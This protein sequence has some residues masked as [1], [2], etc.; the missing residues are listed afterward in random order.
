MEMSSTQKILIWYEQ[1]TW[2]RALL[3]V[4]P[5]GASLDILLTGKAAQINQ[6]RLN[7]L[8]E[9]IES[10]VR[11]LEKPLSPKFLQSENFFELFRT[12]A[13]IVCRSASHEKRSIVADCLAGA[14][15]VETVTDL[16]LQVMED[17]RSM[18][19]MHIQVLTAI[20]KIKGQEV[21]KTQ[22]PESLQNMPEEVY[23]KAIADL[24]RYGFIR[25][26]TAG[27]G[28]FGGGSGRWQTTSYVP[29]FHS[30][31]NTACAL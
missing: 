8:I 10:R 26:N 16:R 19:M 31:I 29:I 30:Q 20:P 1:A 22:K 15:Q 13:E 7:E 24:E 27:I 21:S 11:M 17:L 14:I 23:E 3:Q 18:H 2:L 28:N 6:R 5:G 12:A 9:N 4:P 25:L